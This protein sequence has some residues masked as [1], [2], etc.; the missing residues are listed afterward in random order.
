MNDFMRPAVYDAWHGIEPVQARAGTGM[1]CDVVGPVCESSDYL[2][3][4]REL[5]VRPGDLLAVRDVGAYGAS[6]ACEYNTRP[7]PLRIAG[8]WRDHPPNKSP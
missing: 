2:G 6:M 7:S 3:K 4:D 5:D 8:G 1:V